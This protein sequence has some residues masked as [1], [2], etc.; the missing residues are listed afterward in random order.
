[1]E[2]EEE[3]VFVV[4]QRDSSLLLVISRQSIHDMVCD[5]AF[6]AK[7]VLCIQHQNPEFVHIVIKDLN[8]YDR[9]LWQLGKLLQ[10]KVVHFKGLKG[11]IMDRVRLGRMQQRKANSLL[12]FGLKRL[13]PMISLLAVF[14]KKQCPSYPFVMDVVHEYNE[15]FQSQKLYNK[16]SGRRKTERISQ[17]VFALK[18]INPFPP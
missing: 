1:M 6:E 11:K 14:A 16:R 9:I 8:D 18:R 15:L 2:K 12:I 10:K 5:A 7:V 17:G 4:P 3:G 13:K